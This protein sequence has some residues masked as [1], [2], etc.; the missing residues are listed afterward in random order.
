MK[1]LFICLATIALSSSPFIGF[2]LFNYS[3]INAKK[4][5]KSQNDVQ[6]E[7]NEKSNL[8]SNPQDP[9]DHPYKVNNEQQ[10]F[11]Q[12]SGVSQ[13]II[14]TKFED[15]NFWAIGED[16]TG[17]DFYVSHDYGKTWN[18]SWSWESI[19]GEGAFD[20]SE[21]NVFLTAGGQI[22]KSTDY[23][24]DFTNVKSIPDGNGTAL[25]ESGSNI[26]VGTF[27]D[28]P[29]IFYSNDYGA[30]W[31]FH[32]S[33]WTR[34][35]ISWGSY[36][37]NGTN[38]NGLW[39]SDDAGASWSQIGFSAGPGVQITALS[40]VDGTVYVGLHF[41]GGNTGGVW[42]GGPTQDWQKTSDML[43]NA[44]FAQTES[45]VY[46]GGWKNNLYESTASGED[47]NEVTSGGIGGTSG[48]KVNA[49]FGNGYK[50]ALAMNS[51]GLWQGDLLNDNGVEPFSN[52]FNLNQGYKM[53]EDHNDGLTFV[54]PSQQTIVLKPNADVEDNG[55]IVNG[56]STS[57]GATVNLNDNGFQFNEVDI[58][59]KNKSD[60][61]NYPL[62]DPSTGIVKVYFEIQDGLNE[63]PTYS[64]V[65]PADTNFYQSL[66]ANQGNISGWNIEQTSSKDEASEPAMAIDC[67]IDYIDPNN[68]Y[69]ISGSLY[70]EGT[71]FE[72][73]GTKIPLN[74]GSTNISQKGIYQVHLQDIFGNEYDSLVEI[75]KTN[76]QAPGGFND[77]NYQ[78]LEKKLN[79]S[80]AITDP[81]NKTGFGTW[82]TQY[83]EY[84]A[85]HIS[86][87]F[88]AEVKKTGRGFDYSNLKN[89]WEQKSLTQYLDPI[90]ITDT[91]KLPNYQLDFTKDSLPKIAKA[92]DADLNAESQK[93]WNTGV[94]KEKELA[95]E[96]NVSLNSPEVQKEQ[97][98][99]DALN[100]YSTFLENYKDY[101]KAQIP[102]IFNEET[103]KIGHGYDYSD[104]EKNWDN[105]N[106]SQL[107]Q[108]L[109]PISITDTTK[110]PNYQL[111]FTKDSLPKIAKAIDADLNAESQKDYNH[112]KDGD[113]KLSSIEN[114]SIDDSQIQKDQNWNNDLTKYNQFLTDYKKYL[115]TNSKTIVDQAITKYD[116]GYM[117]P[118]Q[119]SKI[120][121]D[122]LQSISN[123]SMDLKTDYL[124]HLNWN[125]K[126]LD[127]SQEF[128][129]LINMKA[130]DAEV[131]KDLNDE[132]PNPNQQLQNDIDNA[133]KGVDLYGF[134]VQQI[135]QHYGKQLPQNKTQINNFDGKGASFHNWLV[136]HALYFHNETQNTNQNMINRNTLGI[137]LGSVFGGL[138]VIG[139]FLFFFRRRIKEHFALKEK[140]RL[141]KELANNESEEN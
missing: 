3:N 92:I 47:F 96:E 137:I 69:Y 61:I 58:Q 131:Q 73:T 77:K 60:A 133:E 111:D 120:E 80:E 98:W 52:F 70:D 53:S 33:Y 68:S 45:D 30:T 56:K 127:N 62:G 46:A 9:S 5:N 115:D 24:D 123:G 95:N 38:N 117:T 44:L 135:L 17:Y 54:Y 74:N 64:A 19:D 141:K 20:F 139:L 102:L 71:N 28:Y 7:N 25:S 129:S 83:Q 81:S 50:I 15:N 12:I 101:I 124:N 16:S 42:V 84:I 78:S 27:A 43:V 87:I 118:S 65:N 126:T 63:N 49:I 132:D 113:S 94:A 79:I 103:S 40:E 121:N 89:E 23:G 128:Q 6:N 136:K 106:L 112:Q 86:T 93:D 35:L 32:A 119:E 14:Q 8:K 85:S 41:K 48:W 72:P 125:T 39:E 108:Y 51:H 90:S 104:V 4:V 31:H 26:Y 76:W 59:L 109:D 37:F 29:G 22:L 130:I 10:N 36:V 57:Q 114:V 2:G 1:K 11:K 34:S 13:T 66:T 110:L 107:T 105:T 55:Y 75:G 122:V 138:F 18:I 116:L 21:N 91:T 97:N 67:N 82:L 88:D 100:K 140:T 134:S 99:Q